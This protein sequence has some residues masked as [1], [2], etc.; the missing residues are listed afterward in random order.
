[1]PKLIDIQDIG[2]IEVPD[3][4]GENEL[5]EF[6]DTLDQGALSSAG[7]AFMR[8]GG[9]MVGGSMMG[10]ARLASEEPPP[11]MTAAQAESPAGM[12]AYNRRLEAWQ[13]RT[14]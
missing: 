4:V 5:Q 9:R 7:S 2:L 12:E 10:L 6:V 3:D 14:R 13:Q 11:M 1:M 8:E